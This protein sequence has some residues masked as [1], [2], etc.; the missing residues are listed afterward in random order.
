[1][2]LHEAHRRNAV[3]TLTRAQRQAEE[4]FHRATCHKRLPDDVLGGLTG[5]C[6]TEMA[7]E[8]YLVAED[9]NLTVHH[10]RKRFS[11]W[12]RIVRKHPGAL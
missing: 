7:P 4:D 8:N 1:M 6:T 11:F 3:S 5:R 2:R 12:R 9:F 10:R